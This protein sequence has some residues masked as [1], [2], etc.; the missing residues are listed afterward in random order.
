MTW[1]CWLVTAG[2]ILANLLFD[3]AISWWLIAGIFFAPLLIFLAIMLCGFVVA[4]TVTLGASRRS[5]R[6]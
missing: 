3:A 1:V 4:L 6:R 5:R 2:L